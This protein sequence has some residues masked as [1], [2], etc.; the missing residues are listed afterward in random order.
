VSSQ[1]LREA[2]ALMR[3]RAEA[4]TPGPWHGHDDGWG[5]WTLAK[6]NAPFHEL[7][8][9]KCGSDD[10]PPTAPDAEHIAS[11]HPAVA[12]AVAD[13]LDEVAQAWGLVE[14]SEEGAYDWDGFPIR[15]EETTDAGALAVARAFLGRQP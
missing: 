11:W 9:L 6:P 7:N 8:V 12:L 15:F 3:S 14:E 5:G 4:A 13:W 1:I 2:A 10:W